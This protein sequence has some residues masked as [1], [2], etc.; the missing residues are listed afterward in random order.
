[1][2]QA[3]PHFRGQRL[4]PQYHADPQLRAGVATWGKMMAKGSWMGDLLREREVVAVEGK[5]SCRTLFVHAGLKPALLQVRAC[6][7]ACVLCRL[8]AHAS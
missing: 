4:T 5:G 7:P 1:M 8:A 2:Q 6:L 3:P